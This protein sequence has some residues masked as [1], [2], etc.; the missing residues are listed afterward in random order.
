MILAKFRV[1][2]IAPASRKLLDGTDKKGLNVRAVP[3]IG[4][5]AADLSGWYANSPLS[6]V[7]FWVFEENSQPFKPG[8]EFEMVVRAVGESTVS[9]HVVVIPSVGGFQPAKLT[10]K[11]GD[12]V[13]WVAL[14]DNPRQIEAADGSWK[15]PVL[16]SKPGEPTVSFERVFP[17]AG[18]FVYR[19]VDTP[20]LTG[21]VN[22]L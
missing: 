14:G 1:A 15:S 9:N 17:A 3:V 19:Y 16:F 8:Y 5:D 22:V 13:I 6:Q 12:T 18:T 20:R 2:A 10:I 21:T 4:P 11:A 7:G